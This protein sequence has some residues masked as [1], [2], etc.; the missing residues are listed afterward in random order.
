M[1]KDQMVQFIKF[2][3]N[4][5]WLEYRYAVNNHAPKDT[6]QYF[7]TRHATL[8]QLMQ[9]LQIIDTSPNS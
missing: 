2:E 9:D 5:S 4:K 8:Y 1:T 7:R 3:E 6:I